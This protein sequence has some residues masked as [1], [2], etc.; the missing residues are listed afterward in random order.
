VRLGVFDSGVGGLTVVREI[1]ALLP[2]LSICYLGDSLHAPYGSRSEDE[3]R[4][5]SLGQ[6]QFL[7][8]QGC[9]ALVIACNTATAAA[10]RSLRVRFP[11]LPIVGM[12]PAVKPAAAATKT[13]IIGV[14]ATVGTLQSARFAAL[15][16]QFAA[17]LTVLT[18][19]CPGWVEAVERGQM[20]APETHALLTC[21]VEPLLVTGADTLVLGCTHFPALRP[22]LQALVGPDVALIDTGAAVAR[23]V[24]AL[25]PDELA[26]SPTTLGS[27]A[28]FTSGNP[29]VF[30]ESARAIL[31]MGLPPTTKQLRWKDGVLEHA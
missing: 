19:S 2:T 5:L 23:R 18:R 9:T 27:L 6:A 30:S 26:A 28:L 13:G 14:L 25:L 8:A 1:Q 4:S 31:G 22:Q 10:A 7:Q 12:E 16:D 24:A 15:L 21:E 11:E 29:T 3:I 17:H 20:E